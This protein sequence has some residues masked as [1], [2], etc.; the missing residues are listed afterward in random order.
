MGLSES[1]ID[2]MSRPDKDLSNLLLGSQG[3]NVWVYANIYDYESSMVH[4]GQAV[5]LSSPALPGE[6]F[7][8]RSGRSTP[9][10]IMR[11]GP[12]GSASAS[13]ILKGI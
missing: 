5:E 10:S 12:C 7:R 11:Q 2:E 6:T 1:Q 3:K 9:S 8:E 13:P 4:P